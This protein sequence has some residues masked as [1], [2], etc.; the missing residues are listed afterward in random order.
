MRMGTLVPH[1]GEVASRDTIIRLAA[2]AEALGFRS[3]WV[4]DHLIWSPHGMEGSNKTFLDPF[5]TLAAIAAVTSGCTLGTG[6]T[7]PIRW[8]LKL[9][10]NYATLSFLNQGNVVAGLGL[11][12]SPKEFSAA[13]LDADR[14]ED[15]LRETV[16]ILRA[17]WTQETVTYH[18][19][20]FSV[21]DVEL[22][23]KPVEPIPIV[24]GG[25]TPKSVRRALEL[26]E[27]WY[28]GRLPMTT[29]KA[30]LDYLREVGGEKAER[31]YTI[32][33]PLV[34]VADTRAEAEALVPI[35]EVAHSSA[36]AKFWIKPPSGKFRTVQDLA[37][38]VVCGTP[39]D[40]AE[41]V[42]E[43]AEL[44]IDEFIFDFRLQF[45]RYEEAV[46]MVGERVLPQLSGVRA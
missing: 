39:D 31:M 45:D 44:G 24:Y 14:R 11:G 5:L 15:I 9:A 3:F 32:I 8:P 38:L 40:V 35:E 41:Q 16:D 2:R 29:L 25:N 23:P 26:S 13:G 4:R 22:A 12:F 30:R 1:F 33:Q 20:V 10:Q 17:A 42:A 27:G 37:G 6:V 43:F 18:G 34:V 7:I 28:P 46:E 21:D 19:D 36:G